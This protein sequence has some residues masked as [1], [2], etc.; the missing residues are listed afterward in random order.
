MSKFSVKV[1]NDGNTVGIGPRAIEAEDEESAR[2]QF[3]IQENMTEEVLENF[4]L[5]TWEIIP[6]IPV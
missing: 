4:G 3:L 2:K 6:I 1:H 5:L